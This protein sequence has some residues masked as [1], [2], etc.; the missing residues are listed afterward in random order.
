MKKC[1]VIFSGGQDSTT[2]LGWAIKQ[3]NYIECI[4]FNY[5]QIHSIEIEQAKIIC[6]KYKIKQT[7]IDISFL[8]QIVDSALTS[9][10]NVNEKHSRLKNLP[11]SFVPNRNGLFI[12]LAHS[13]AQKVGIEN[14]IGGMCEEDFS[15]YPDCRRKFIDLFI[16]SLNEG[17]E[18]DIEIITPL[19][20]LNKAQTFLLAEKNNILK[21]VIELSHTCYNG[22]R[23]IRN[24]WGYGCGKCPACL[25]RKKGWE[26]YI[27]IYEI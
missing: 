3:F 24:E 22:N 16:N 15:G 14:I 4:T 19:M 10:G 5:G 20:H 25:L 1:L 23:E 11:A 17:S 12:L 8:G 2:C 13:Y 18:A 6:E 27:K 9:N 7:I 26:E 21:D